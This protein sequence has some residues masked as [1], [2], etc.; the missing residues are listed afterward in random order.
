MT[1]QELP[2]KDKIISPLIEQ[3]QMPYQVLIN[4]LGLD[5]PV[6]ILY[7]YFPQSI[8]PRQIYFHQPALLRFLL[9]KPPRV[10]RNGYHLFFERVKKPCF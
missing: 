5:I 1:K 6:R 8:D 9:L 2:Q 3:R 7:S 10:C 4:H